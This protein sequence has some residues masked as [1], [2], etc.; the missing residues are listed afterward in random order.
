MDYLINQL[1]ECQSIDWLV[2]EPAGNASFAAS[3]ELTWRCLR[4]ARAKASQGRQTP[5]GRLQA[6][7]C[8]TTFLVLAVHAPATKIRP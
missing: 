7:G 5:D 4:S 8:A 3:S 1:I 2:L 6:M